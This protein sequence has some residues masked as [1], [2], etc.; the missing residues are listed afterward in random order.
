MLDIAKTVFGMLKGKPLIRKNRV[1]KIMACVIILF[2]L[3]C[4]YWDVIRLIGIPIPPRF[5]EGMRIFLKER[6][7]PYFFI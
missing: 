5:P 6:L 1:I 4:S 3:F 7:Y 2:T